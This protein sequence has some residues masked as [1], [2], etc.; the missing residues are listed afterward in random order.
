[1]QQTKVVAMTLDQKG[2]R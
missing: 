2:G 1:M